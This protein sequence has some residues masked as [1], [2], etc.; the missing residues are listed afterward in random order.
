MR[1][2]D[3]ANSGISLTRQRPTNPRRPRRPDRAGP[4]NDQQ[5]DRG[6]PPA[7]ATQAPP[8]P[9]SRTIRR[10]HEV[11]NCRPIARH[12]RDQ[13]L[14]PI[15]NV[16]ERHIACRSISR[17]GPMLWA[18]PIE[19]PE[20]DRVTVGRRDVGMGAIRGGRWTLGS[21]NSITRRRCAAC[22]MV[23]ISIPY[24]RDQ[25][26]QDGGSDAQRT[27]EHLVQRS[28]LRVRP[29]LRRT[30]PER[31]IARCVQDP[32]AGDPRVNIQKSKGGE[33]KPYQIR[34]VLKAID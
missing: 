24:M 33:A 27:A 21:C 9:L 7:S 18:P 6:H 4:R 31:N 11:R 2:P 26:R 8:Q 16:P 19:M 23:P 10:T 15:W 32:V 30:S 12:F 29:L 13:P 34:Q 14:P 25:D 22:G 5:S 20:L 1:S 17:G 28:S 3:D